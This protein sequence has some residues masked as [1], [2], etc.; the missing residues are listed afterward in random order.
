MVCVCSS[1]FSSPPD[2]WLLVD[3]TELKLV[4]GPFSYQYDVKHVRFFLSLL[5]WFIGGAGHALRGLYRVHQFSKV[6]LFGLTTNEEGKESSNLL[7]EIME[8]QKDI[9]NDLGLHYR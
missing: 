4:S 2:W 3:A 6:E 9:L 5:T 7:E 1:C 8:L